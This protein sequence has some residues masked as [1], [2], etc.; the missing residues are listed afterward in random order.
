MRILLQLGIVL[1]LLCSTA[2]AQTLQVIPDID[3]LAAEP[4][5]EVTRST[6]GT[7]QA[8]TLRRNGV[9]IQSSRQR[10]TVGVDESG[11]GAVMC[12]WAIYVQIKTSVDLCGSAQA[13]QLGS[14]LDEAIAK[15]NDF[16]AANSLVPT[17][18]QAVAAAVT[19]EENKAKAAV[20]K[21]G[22]GGFAKTCSNP[23]IKQMISATARMSHAEWQKTVSD[24]ISI[25]R[26]PVMNPCL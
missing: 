16:I 13:P 21:L 26:P 20:A 15:L 24:L 11:H 23:D 7:V 19:A 5:A 25:P 12:T 3:H 14:E 22:E 18:V 8:V 10:G 9:A 6:D 4:G 17:T 2:R 1:V